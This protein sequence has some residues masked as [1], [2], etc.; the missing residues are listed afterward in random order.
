VPG[1]HLRSS[2]RGLRREV[3][4]GRTGDYCPAQ[5]FV[6]GFLLNGRSRLTG[7]T[8]FTIDDA[9]SPA[10][11]EGIEVYRGLSSVPAEFLNPDS[12]CGVVVVWTR[13]D[14]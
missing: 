6:D 13:R 8:E 1:V 7:D 14:R 2:G 4:M 5:I 9:V 10:S 12:R 3:Y 11:I